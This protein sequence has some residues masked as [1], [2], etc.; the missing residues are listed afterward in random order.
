MEESVTI[1]S[2]VAISVDEARKIVTLNGFNLKMEAKKK[3]V[4]D[5]GYND[6]KAYV[7]GDLVEYLDEGYSIV[8]DYKQIKLLL[9]LNNK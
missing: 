7:R 3:R 4:Y 2:G 5:I 6:V 1:K 8:L 9:I